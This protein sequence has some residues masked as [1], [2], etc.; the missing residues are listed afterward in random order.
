MRELLRFNCK[1]S[2]PCCCRPR[3][4]VAHAT[5]CSQVVLEGKFTA[6]KALIRG[7][8]TCPILDTTLGP[9]ARAARVAADPNFKC[10]LEVGPLLD[11]VPM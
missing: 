5:S 10:F 9:E 4:D 7:D 11:K 2:S 6:V 8:V 3:S 1:P